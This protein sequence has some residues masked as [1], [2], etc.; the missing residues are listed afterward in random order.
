MSEIQGYLA[1]SEAGKRLTEQVK[2]PPVQ[3]LCFKSAALVSATFYPDA[4]RTHSHS[5][6]A[7][8]TKNI[9]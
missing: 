8:L 9:G 5:Q 4:S 7:G 3:G 1:Y 6:I 2:T